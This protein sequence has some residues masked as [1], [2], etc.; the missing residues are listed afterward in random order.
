MAWITLPL[1]SLKT[2]IKLHCSVVQTGVNLEN[3]EMIVRKVKMLVTSGR[4]G[5]VFIRE[6]PWSMW[7]LVIF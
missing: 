7:G 5:V 6:D 3:K 1:F 4:M 2:K